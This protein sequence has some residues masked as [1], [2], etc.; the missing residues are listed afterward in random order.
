MNESQPIFVRIG[1]SL[2][3]EPDDALRWRPAYWFVA[4]ILPL[5]FFAFEALKIFAYETAR[6]P[7]VSLMAQLLL[8][9]F[10]F[11]VW[12]A[13][14][15]IG[16]T[17]VSRTTGALGENWP[18]LTALVA[19][20]GLAM[21]ALHLFLLAF[22]LRLMHAPSGWGG[23]LRLA[24]AFGEVWLGN[25]GVWLIA[26]AVAAGAIIWAQSY[27]KRSH[28]APARIEVRHAGKLLSVPLADIRWIKAAGNYVELHTSRGVFMLRKT[29]TEIEKTTAAAGFLKSHRGAIVNARHVT[30]VRPLPNSDG[31]TVQLE[32]GAEAPLSRRKLTEFR[33]LLN[34]AE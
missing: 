22:L 5:I 28:P 33:A 29:L 18:R 24:K 12:V 20:L 10:F 8:M 7:N 26:Y 17:A 14:P 15:R 30:A 4:A 11:S 25:A 6:A 19:G 1:Q 2:F 21:S 3:S 32:G 16:W 27:A 34:S 13:V 23:P 9:L 31:F